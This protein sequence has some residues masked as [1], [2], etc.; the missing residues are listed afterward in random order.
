MKC[1]RIIDH[2]TFQ[3]SGG[4]GGRIQELDWNGDVLWDFRW[5]SEAGLSHHD[6][7]ILP[8]GNILL[9][10]WDRTTRDAAL[11]AGRDPELL[12]GDEFW[13]CGVYEIKPTYPE[14][15]DV[16]WSWHTM[17]HLVQARD[18][19]LP[20]YGVPSLFPHRV[21]INGDFDDQPMSDEE[22]QEEK[23]AM[24]AIGYG[25]GADDAGETTEAEDRE[26]A[27]RKARTKDADWMHTNA[28]DYHAGL[29]QIVLSVRRFDEVWIIDHGITTEEAKGPKGDLLYRWGNPYAYG[30]G[31]WSQR[32]LFG[33][34]HVQW[35]PEGMLGAGNL[36]LFNNGA[37]DRQFSTI[38]EFWPPLRSDG[39]YAREEGKPWGP[40]ETE[41]TYGSDD[42]EEFSSRFISGVQRLASGNTLVCSGAQGWVF[43]LTPKG[44]IVWDWKNPY[45]ARPD[46]KEDDMADFP[47]AIFRAER[48][49][50]DSPEI[51]AL[52]KRG[53][54]IPE[55]A[56]MGPATNQRA[57]TDPQVQESKND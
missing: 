32:S 36:I 48:F 46:E 1:Q 54:P 53:A 45:G 33:Q 34:H 15:G 43:E 12:A 26:A 19:S 17:D 4:L 35:I 14:G 22:E 29:D 23:D 21:D 31:E 11:A 28:I 16:V 13:S 37:K 47:S 52:R 27:E 3:D 56:G 40:T 10:A 18:E 7:E 2:E 50:A 8:N 20:N 57:E 30:M 5:D 38:E 41:W 49:A 44:D 42:P 24:A 55:S 51:N 39:T 6:I 25:G 9:I